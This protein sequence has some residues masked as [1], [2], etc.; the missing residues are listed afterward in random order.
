M[1]LSGSIEAAQQRFSLP[2]LEWYRKVRRDLPWRRSRNPYHIWI[3]EIMLQQTRVETVIPYYNR[4]M[5]LFPTVDKLA[6]APE[7]QVLKAWEGL[8]YYSRARNLQAAAREVVEQHGGVVPDTLEGVSALRGIGPYT[9]GAILSIAYNKP[10]PAVDGNVMRVLSRYFELEEDIAK[11]S[12]RVGIEKLAKALIPQGEAGDFNQALMELGA[13]ICTP[14]AAHC[15]PCPVMERCAARLAGRVEELPVKAKA[16][17]PRPE[18]RAVALIEGAGSNA[19]RILIRQRPADGLLARLWELPHV[20]L[21]QDAF[22][23]APGSLGAG[24]KG[25]GRPAAPR[26]ADGRE[27]AAADMDHGRIMGELGQRLSAEDG[28]P[29]M[30]GEWLMNAEHI[31]SHIRWDLAVYRCRLAPPSLPGLISRAA[32]PV[33]G[34]AAAGL[35]AAEHSPAYETAVQPPQDGADGGHSF[36]GPMPPERAAAWE[37]NPLRLSAVED[38]LPPHYRWIALDDMEHY[39]FPN[40]FLRILQAYRE[41]DGG[42]LE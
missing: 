37:A 2:L 42:G 10:E 28:V 7:E 35:T 8:G 17:P 21:P 5:E 38:G 24:A 40:V 19:G 41:G 16:K 9:A 3:S 34:T 20:E 13:T 27:P 6:A 25:R 39:T 30:A 4:F 29:V 23:L 15:L 36:A 32:P 1:N 11:P 14:K 12:T 31:F 18:A 26:P 33:R 22:G